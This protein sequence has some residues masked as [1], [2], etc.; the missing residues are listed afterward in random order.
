M[1]ESS[2]SRPHATVV[3]AMSAD[4]KISDV[5]RSNEK[6]GSAADFAHLEQQVAI[7]D[8]VIVGAGT[9]RMGDTA[10]RVISEEWLESR[11]KE[12][13]PPQPV[14]IV[15]TRSGDLDAGAKFFSQPIPR[16]LL[17]TTEGGKRWQNNLGFDRVLTV[18]GTDGNVDLTE[19][20]R[21]LYDLGLRRLAVLGG[22]TFIAELFRR[23]LVDELWLTV[24]PYIFGGKEAPTPVDGKGF[25]SGSFP[26]LKLLDVNPAGEEVFLHYRVERS[27]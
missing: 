25:S 13:K 20:F 26:E 6:F 9:L 8:G 5:T 16:W 24:C 1:S 3:L 2:S 15:C 12:G 21:Q 19:A 10:M 11:K 22:G 4:G 23:Q 7:A 14:Q 27:I 18:D 17:T